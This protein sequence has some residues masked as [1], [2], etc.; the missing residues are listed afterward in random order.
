MRVILNCTVVGRKSG[1]NRAGVR[2][3]KTRPAGALRSSSRR[4]RRADTKRRSFR[5]DP[6]RSTP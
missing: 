1:P 4:R 2:P 6:R 3:R 5:R